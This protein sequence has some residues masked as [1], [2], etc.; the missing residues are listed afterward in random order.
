MRHLPYGWII[1]AYLALVLFS[2]LYLTSLALELKEKHPWLIDR[3]WK[4]ILWLLSCLLFIPYLVTM[5]GFPRFVIEEVRKFLSGGKDLTEKNRQ[6]IN[7]DK[8]GEQ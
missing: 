4:R 6:G 1:A 3:R 7:R 5:A 8:K 2:F